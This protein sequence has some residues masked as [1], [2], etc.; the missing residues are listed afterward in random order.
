MILIGGSIQE[1][2]DYMNNDLGNTYTY[3]CNLWWMNY[4]NFPYK[5]YPKQVTGPQSYQQ[6]NLEKLMENF[7]ATQTPRKSNLE[8]IMENF[9]MTQKSP[10]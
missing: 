7:I 1:M 5:D 10:K 3:T 6:S 8:T 4:L 9:V 2:E